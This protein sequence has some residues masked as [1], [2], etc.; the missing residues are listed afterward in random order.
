M[1]GGN[2]DVKRLGLAFA[3]AVSL[4]LGGCAERDVASSPEVTNGAAASSVNSTPDSPV[5]PTAARATAIRFADLQKP[6]AGLPPPSLTSWAS[7]KLWRGEARGMI[8]RKAGPCT[9]RPTGA[10]VGVTVEFFSMPV[11]ETIWPSA[12]GLVTGDHYDPLVPTD[13]V[14]G[15]SDWVWADVKVSMDAA[16]GDYLL[17]LGDLPVTLEVEESK[18]PERP[19]VPFYVGLQPYPI[20]CGH[21]LDKD[22]DVLTQGPLVK[23][24]VDLLRAHMIEPF[25]QFLDVPVVRDGRPDIDEWQ[26]F[27]G[28]FRQLVLDGAIAPPMLLSGPFAKDKWELRPRDWDLEK[29]L[30]AWESLVSSDSTA[31]SAFAGSWVYVTDEPCDDCGN[32]VDPGRAGTIARAQ[33]LKTYAPSLRRMVTHVPDPR[34]NDLIDIF[35]P[36][37]EDFKPE[38]T[39]KLGTSQSFWIY[40]ACPSHESCSNFH[41]G[42]NSGT[43]DLMLDQ[44]SI[45]ARAFPIVAAALGGKAMLYYTANEGYGKRDVWT[46]QF[47]FGGNGDG[48]LVYPGIKG[49]RGFGDDEAV[50]SIRLKLL[51]QGMFDVERMLKAGTLSQ[52]VQSAKSWS[53]DHTAIDR[54]AG[55]LPR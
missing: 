7:L 12:N 29:V 38:E 28:S 4:T 18:M 50:G 49:E 43:P 10:P 25:G 22:S 30:S 39:D 11:F 19:T 8:L 23:K 41:E 36:L 15:S 33:M 24:Y 16:P 47:D 52:I 31:D 5:S 14:C 54:A 27:G 13:S 9:D 55:R 48:Q 6:G 32:N 21:R 44:S 42:A 53:Q 46:D 20:L 2:L 17:T 45:H 37:F 51:R 35:V 3:A 1:W 34:L 26:E 40:G